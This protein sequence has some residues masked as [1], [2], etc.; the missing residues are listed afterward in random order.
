[1]K[2]RCVDEGLMAQLDDRIWNS[3]LCLSN[4][5]NTSARIREGAVT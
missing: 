5:G 3:S 2:L 4:I 1:M